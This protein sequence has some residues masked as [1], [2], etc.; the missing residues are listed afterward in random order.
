[1]TLTR[2]DL[3]SKPM[4]GSSG[5]VI[6]PSLRFFAINLVAA[7]VGGIV[8]TAAG[9]LFANA[10]VAARALSHLYR[11]RDCNSYHRV[12]LD[13]GSVHFEVETNSSIRISSISYLI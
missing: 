10:I 13:N 12:W 4:P 6:W 11:P 7:V 3:P 9:Y 8:V 2:S 5:A 1:M